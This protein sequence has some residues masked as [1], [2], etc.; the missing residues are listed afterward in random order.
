VVRKILFVEKRRE[1]KDYMVEN[2]GNPET[3]GPVG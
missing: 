1:E 2:A 3:G